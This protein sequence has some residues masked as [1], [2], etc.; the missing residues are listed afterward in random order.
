VHP[1]T[2]NVAA[3]LAAAGAAGQ[4]RELT[5]SARTAADAAAAL[6]CEVGAIANSLV[7]LADGS[8]VLVLT[9]GA[10]RVDPPH[11]AAQLG[12]RAV[13]RAT[14]EQVRAATGQVIGG[15][16]PVGHPAPVRTLLDEALAAFPVVW[17]AAGTPHAVFP[18]T[19]AELARI[20]AAEPV[21]VAA[22]MGT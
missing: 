17:A 5:E 9:S 20:C 21:T 12:V 14:P 11:L 15:V 13:R 18:T 6:G 16:S 3:A 4:V 19:Y 2:Q 10:H 1:Q 22:P 7:F 8:P